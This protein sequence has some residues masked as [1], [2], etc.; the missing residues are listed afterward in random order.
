MLQVGP[1]SSRLNSNDAFLL[2]AAGGVWLWKG[3]G[4]SAAEAKGAEHLA[5]VLQVN[6]APLEEGEEPGEPQVC[7]VSGGPSRR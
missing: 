2:M 5:Q 1:S 3:R 6:P 4:S 7:R